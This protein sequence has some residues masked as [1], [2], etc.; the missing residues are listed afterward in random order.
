[1]EFN[2]APGQRI[3]VMTPLQGPPPDPD[4]ILWTAIDGT[5]A[6]GVSWLAI[7]PST[8][9]MT[10][11]VPSDIGPG[12]YGIGLRADNGCFPPAEAQITFVIDEPEPVGPFSSDNPPRTQPTGV[13]PVDS[14]V[15]SG[16][17][18]TAPAGPPNGP[19]AGGGTFYVENNTWN[20][21]QFDLQGGGQSV[22]GSTQ[23]ANDAFSFRVDWDFPD[24][25]VPT[26]GGTATEV[27]SFPAAYVGQNPGYVNTGHANLPILAEDI[28]SLWTGYESRTGSVGN[29]VAHLAHDARLMNSPTVWPDY[30]AA[31][32]DIFLELFVVV[33]QFN[34][35]GVHPGGRDPARYH[36]QYNIGGVDWHFYIQPG[37]TGVPQYIWIPVNFP[38]PN[39]LDFASLIKWARATRGDSLTQN[40]GPS[41]SGALAVP[42]GPLIPAG[43]YFTGSGLGYELTNGSG[44]STVNNW[45]FDVNQ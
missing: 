28:H 23:N 18:Q 24:N 15:V 40:P 3:H 32:P 41:G 44:D 12:R 43:K 34:G 22:Q 11:T 29:S 9:A 1:M 6:N 17:F 30:N 25:P 21:N 42:A 36:G 37:A 35:Y 13:N 2:V 45:W 19:P 20:F 27:I 14:T 31:V 8:G 4:T 7:D 39:P 16:G 10:G 33:A 5:E 26:G 38:A